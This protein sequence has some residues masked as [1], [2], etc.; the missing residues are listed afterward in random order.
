MT[1]GMNENLQILDLA[2][3]A[4][5]KPFQGKVTR[6]TFRATSGETVDVDLRDY[7][8]GIFRKGREV[9]CLDLE[10]CLTSSQTLDWIFQIS[11]KDWATQALLGLIIKALDAALSPQASLCCGGAD[12]RIKQADIR[13]IVKA[14]LRKAIAWQDEYRRDGI[15]IFCKTQ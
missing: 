3:L 15:K 13:N 1:A 4:D 7:D 8:L 6:V 11:G 12:L 14:N 5:C 2:S 9:Y 10:R